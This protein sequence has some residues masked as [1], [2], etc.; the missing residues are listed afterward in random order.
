VTRCGKRLLLMSVLV[1]PGLSPF[2]ILI[3]GLLM[4]EHQREGDAQT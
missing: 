3:D 1:L 4:F 2:E